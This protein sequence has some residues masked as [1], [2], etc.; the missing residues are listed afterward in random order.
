M[1]GRA[2]AQAAVQIHPADALVGPAFND[3]K[4]QFAG[5]F[6]IPGFCAD[7]LE[8]GPVT[9][10]A[11]LGL[12]GCICRLVNNLVNISFLGSLMLRSSF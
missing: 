3:R 12:G 7:Y 8:F 6:R 9:I 5:G 2:G 1:A 4:F 10:I 11:S